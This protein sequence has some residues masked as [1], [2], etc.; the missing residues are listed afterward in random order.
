MI[1]WVRKVV[2]TLVTDEEG[3]VSMLT[4]EQKYSFIVRMIQKVQA[5]QT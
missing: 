5:L 3:D 1:E 4:N 2:D